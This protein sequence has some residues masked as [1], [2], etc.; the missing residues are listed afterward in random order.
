MNE[1][2]TFGRHPAD[3]R[4][5]KEGYCAAGRMSFRLKGTP[6]TSSACGSSRRNNRF[7]Y[8]HRP[9][10]LALGHTPSGRL[11]GDAGLDEVVTASWGLPK[12]PTDG[13]LLA[14]HRSVVTASIRVADTEVAPPRSGRRVGPRTLV[15]SCSISRQLVPRND[16]LRWTP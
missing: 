16:R 13:V 9:V 4:R 6:T 2:N 12:G 7:G 8:G 11:G 1:A 15:A 14:C 5:S 3:R 10:V